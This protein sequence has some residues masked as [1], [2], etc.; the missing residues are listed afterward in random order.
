M[1]RTPPDRSRRAALR[2]QRLRLVLCLDLMAVV[3]FWAC[4]APQQQQGW[5]LSRGPVVPHDTFPSDCSLCHTT[6]SWTVL[7]DDFSFDH[8]AETGVALVGAHDDAQC[9][10]CH[11]DRGPVGRFAARG[12]A[13]C[14]EDFHDGSLGPVCQAC[15]VE[16]DWEPR[17]VVAEH[18]STRFPLVGA[19]AVAQ[20]F[21]CHPGSEAGIYQPTP[22]SCESC[23]QDDLDSA[24]SPDHRSLG[25]VAN[26][27]DCHRPTSWGAEGFVHS[28]FPLTGAHG[29]ADCQECHVG[30]VFQGTPRDCY[31]C[32]SAEYLA[33][34]DPNHALNNFPLECQLCH[35]TEEWDDADFNHV[36]VGN[37]SC[38]ECHL[39]DYQQAS[40]PNHVALNFPQT[41]DQCHN[42]Q[43]WHEG[44][45]DHGAIAQN[46]VQCHAAEYQATTN[47]DHVTLGFPTNCQECHGTAMWQGASFNHNV[48]VGQACVTCH[49]PDFQAT[50]NP[51]HVKQGFPTTCESCH[52]STSSWTGA[53]F[54]HTFIITG[55]P[56]AVNCAVCHVGG[57]PAPPDCR[58]CHPQGEM[59]KEHDEV[60]GYIWSNPACIACHP[61]GVK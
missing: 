41:C 61:T 55:G 1:D 31:S 42:V 10:R 59:A 47:P 3:L 11:N 25:W 44:T 46:C 21:Q 48:A 16:T 35:N 29:R 33:T 22:T 57:P 24:T 18:A 4:A 40:D 6:G 38:S 15:H 12:C 54:N 32:H 58:Q 50:T 2:W 27:Q 60:P 45:F 9:L 36:R 30:G 17:G 37:Q 56:H 7:R 49:L 20:C 43:D 53:T 51:N 23:H 39:Q 13:G 34:T 14:H 28:F 52:F 19:H 5:E 26:C 8:E